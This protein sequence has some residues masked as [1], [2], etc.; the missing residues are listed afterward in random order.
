MDWAKLLNPHRR[1]AR[2]RSAARDPKG[3]SDHRTPFER[4]Y[5]RILFSTPVRRLAD[6]TQV[7]PLEK[8]DSVRTRLTHSHEVS[9]LA[10]SIGTRLVREGIFDGVDGAATAVPSVLAAAGLAHD[11]GN[12]PFGHQ[13]E[14][15]IRSWF[16][17]HPDSLTGV[18][19]DKQQDFLVFEGNAQMLRLITRLQL[20]GDAFGLDLTYAT[21]ATLMKYPV[22][23][24]RTQG[25]AGPIACKKPG[26]FA[27]ESALVEEIWAETGLAEGVR[28][29]LTFLM[30]ACDDIA[31][32]VCD[33]EDAV[34]KQL[35]SFNDVL[36]ALEPG[37]NDL[38]ERVRKRSE[39]DYNR[40]KGEHLSP[41]ELHAISM[42]KFRTYAIGEMVIATSEAFKKHHDRLLSPASL[43]RDLISVSEAHDLR[44]RL[45]SFAK[46]HAYRHRSVLEVEQL[47]YR[48]IRSL[49]D[50]LWDAIQAGDERTP[51]QRFV[52]GAISENYR[53]VFQAA[54]E[55]RGASR[56]YAELRLL[57][58]MV[59]GM[60]DRFALAL[61][62]SLA[63]IVGGA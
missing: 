62:E 61:H 8:H 60:T 45:T 7:F 10:R 42:E 6:K 26:Y 23:S 47:G 54:V 4:D 58:D 34:K 27:S 1:K 55:T 48:T 39:G 52:Y 53:R 44:D 46:A 3:G 30:E 14:Y 19:D 37:S 22:A 16:E 17:S 28:H 41:A 38:T 20:K 56:R 13:G 33:I 40:Y 25:K 49:M 15:A 57:T 51:P 12:P 21:L 24:W 18:S 50:I 35:I 31:Y 32:S 9:N 63:P 5:D 36:S 43:D 11:L 29:P 59:S 2:Q